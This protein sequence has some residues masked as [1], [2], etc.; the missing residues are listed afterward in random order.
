MDVL[1]MTKAQLELLESLLRDV[2][3]A[4]GAADAAGLAKRAAR[5]FNLDQRDADIYEMR[6]NGYSEKATAERH[7]VTQR[8]VRQIVREHL[9]MVRS[10][11]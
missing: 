9:I 3:K 1:A 2:F 8:R 5:D 4:Q 11:A 7:G 6:C 10:I